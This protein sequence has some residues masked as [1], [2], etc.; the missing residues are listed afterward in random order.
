MSFTS[1]QVTRLETLLAANVGAQSVNVDGQSVTYADLL[2]QYD[3]WK[4]RA[5]REQ[6]TRPRV[7]QINLGD[8]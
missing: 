5:A 8:F 7:S 6:G 3:Y 1:D 4:S 2:R